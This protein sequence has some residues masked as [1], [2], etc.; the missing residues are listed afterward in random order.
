MF[1][2]FPHVTIL[3][4]FFMLRICIFM[5]KNNEL[6]GG[7]KQIFLLP[8]LMFYWPTHTFLLNIWLDWGIESPMSSYLCIKAVHRCPHYN[9]SFVP[10]LSALS[11]LSFLQTDLFK[12]CYLGRIVHTHHS[13]RP[14]TEKCF[15]IVPSTVA[16]RPDRSCPLAWLVV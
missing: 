15:V 2:I 12:S 3:Y 1:S 7:I 8:G 9:R 4:I 10:I 16:Q 14:L 11:S 6:W 13:Y 5:K